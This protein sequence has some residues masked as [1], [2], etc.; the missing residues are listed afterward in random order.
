[1]GMLG[2]IGRVRTKVFYILPRAHKF[3]IH[4]R[5]FCGAIGG[6][7]GPYLERRAFS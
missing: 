7:L 5:A 6:K 1:M 3:C 4:L 2:T